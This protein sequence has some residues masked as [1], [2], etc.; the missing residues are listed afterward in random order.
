MPDEIVPDERP[1]PTVKVDTAMLARM[2]AGA[3]GGMVATRVAVGLGKMPFGA[4][5]TGSRLLGVGLPL[6]TSV[7][8]LRWAPAN[9]YT[10]GAAIG[11]AMVSVS[12]LLNW[13]M[14]MMGLA[15]GASSSSDGTEGLRAAPSRVEAPSLPAPESAPAGTA[16]AETA[17]AR[18]A[19]ESAGAQPAGVGGANAGQT[20]GLT[21]R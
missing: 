13:T 9:Q 10:R 4:R 11:A 7:A 3:S 15:P 6:A 14:T 19:A 21:Q 2:T 16:N 12:E 17:G 5:T 20:V 8:M 1:N 18:T